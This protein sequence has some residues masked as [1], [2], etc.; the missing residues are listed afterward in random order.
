M[1]QKNSLLAISAAFYALKNV[2]AAKNCA[3]NNCAE[4]G[5]RQEVGKFQPRLPYCKNLKKFG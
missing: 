2:T 3:H 5:I 4:S 1:D